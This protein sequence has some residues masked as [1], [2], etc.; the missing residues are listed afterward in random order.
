MPYR[1]AY[2][3]V[4][5]LLALSIYAFWPTYYGKLTEA[6]W[7]HH[8]HAA[9]ASVWMLLLVAQNVAIDRRRFALHRRL[10]RAMLVVVPLF[11]ASGLM[12]VQMLAGSRSRFADAFGDRMCF[13]DGF[14]TFAFAAFAY[15]ALA[16]RRNPVVHGGY[17]LITPLLLSQAI[18]TRLNPFDY[19]G[20][21]A[22]GST[23]HEQFVVQHDLAMLLALAVAVAGYLRHRRNSAPF[24]AL[25]VV[26]LVQWVAFYRID[27][28]PGWAATVERIAAMPILAAGAVGLAAGAAAMWFG[29]RA[30]APRARARAAAAAA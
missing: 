3:G 30:A 17:L 8:F 16:N 10:G 11:T 1:R 24:L 28:V 2:W 19:L 20:R 9:T 7:A 27:A 22:P 29:W 4:L 15:A 26:T 14:I 23:P 5:L 18:V 6:S 25:G 21:I 12:V 13:N